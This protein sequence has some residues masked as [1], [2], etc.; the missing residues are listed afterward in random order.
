MDNKGGN[1][2]V[3]GEAVKLPDA[4]PQQ[5]GEVA[6]FDEFLKNREDLKPAGE[7][8]VVAS[9]QLETAGVSEKQSSAM[10]TTDKADDKKEEEEKETPALTELKSIDVPR[11]AEK[12]PPQYVNKIAKI[13]ETD[14]KDP[15]QLVE[16]LDVARWD[17]MRKAFGRQ[18]GD[19]LTG[20]SKE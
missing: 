8:P 5:S 10:P 11:D 9:E 16:D 14:K 6:D 1:I 7:A 3:P 18:M 17:M 19:G 4:A 20:G 13:V 2:Q 15:Y 12:L